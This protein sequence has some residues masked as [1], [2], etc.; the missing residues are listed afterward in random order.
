MTDSAFDSQLLHEVQKPMH[1]SGGFDAYQHGARKLRIARTSL[2]SCH[3]I[4]FT[5]SPV[6]VSNIANA[7]WRACKSHPIILARNSCLLGRGRYWDHSVS[8]LFGFRL[9][10]LDLEL[11]VLKLVEGRSLVHVFH[12]VA[13]HAIDQAGQLG[14]HGL[15]RDGSS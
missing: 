9:E 2:P 1:R 14:G 10:P 3:S 4:R 6:S 7:C 15:D 13:Q 11:S 12:P 8:E 5:S